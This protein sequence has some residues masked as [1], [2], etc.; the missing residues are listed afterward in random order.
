MK[1]GA[2]KVL[3]V[4]V[5]TSG[6]KVSKAITF[7]SSNKKVVAVSKSGKNVKLKAKKNGTAKV[8][9]K[10]KGSPKKTIVINVTVGQKVKSVKLNKTSATLEI[11]QNVKLSA[12][13]SPKKAVNKKIK[14]KSS[15]SG[16]AAVNASGLVVAKNEGTAV[17]TASTQDGSGKKAKCTVTVKKVVRIKSVKMLETDVMKVILTGPSKLTKDNFTIKKKT[18][19]NGTY[20]KTVDIK[21]VYTNDSVTYYVELKDYVGYGDYAQISVNGLTGNS[22]TENFELFYVEKKNTTEYG[23][24]VIRLEYNEKMSEEYVEAGTGYGYRT[25]SWTQ[26]PKGIKAEDCDDGSVILSGTPTEKGAKETVFTFKDEAGATYQT[27]VVFMIYSEDNIIAA[28]ETEYA[29]TKGEDK[30]DVYGYI[31]CSK[32]F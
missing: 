26:L 23:K 19:H 1:K 12:T 9:I 30:A 10:T 28:T 5:K 20:V 18:M 29:I 16:V 27:T 7:K 25:A 3:K 11:G 32:L 6:K 4:S 17:I 15:N 8:T 22:K 2:S 13:V 24:K 21:N 14:W 31:Y